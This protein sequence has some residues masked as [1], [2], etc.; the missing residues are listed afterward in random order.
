MNDDMYEN[1]EQIN[2]GEIMENFIWIAE[3]KQINPQIPMKK[4]EVLFG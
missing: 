1:M 4:Y 3:E 2:I